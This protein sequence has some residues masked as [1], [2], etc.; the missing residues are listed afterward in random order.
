MVSI[1]VYYG[2]PPMTMDAVLATIIAGGQAQIQLNRKV[3]KN[4]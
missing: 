4:L 3:D 2:L 1:L